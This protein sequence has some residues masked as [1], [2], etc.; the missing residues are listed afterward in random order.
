[1]FWRFVA[2]VLGLGLLTV[3][4]TWREVRYKIIGRQKPFSRRYHLLHGFLP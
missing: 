4:P 3:R 1:M 2:R